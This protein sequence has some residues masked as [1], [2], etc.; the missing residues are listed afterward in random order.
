MRI[1]NLETEKEV[2]KMKDFFWTKQDF[3]VFEIEGLTPRMTALQ[4]LIQPKLQ[5][6]GEHFASYFSISLGEEFFSH[7]A[8][9]ARRTINPPSDTWV[10]FAPNKRGYKMLPHFQ[11]GMWDSH[12]FIVVAVIYEV[13]TKMAIA[14][15]LLQQEDILH[16]LPKDFVVSGNHMEK[17]A[18]PVAK[19]TTALLQRMTQI[20]KAEFLIGRHIS[21]E[22][23]IT[24]SHSDFKQ[25]VEETFEALLPIYRIM[26]EAH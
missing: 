5:D 7:V 10:A 25:F 14:Q 22:T 3:E 18:F 2:A 16:A 17:P 12:I 9:H 26:Q 15:Q 8:K 6:L 21:K 23:A 19:E 24:L 4:Q 11:I 20:K 13:P 1:I